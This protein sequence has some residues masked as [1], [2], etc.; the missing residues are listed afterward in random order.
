[1]TSPSPDP[2]TAYLAGV[3]RRDE[4]WHIPFSPARCC[5]LSQ[6]DVPRL[7]AAVEAARALHQPFSIYDE[8]EHD[9]TEAD[10]ASLAA[11]DAGEFLT[12]ADSLIYVICAGCCLGRSAGYGQTQDCAD[13]HDHGE[14]RPICPTHAAISAALLGEGEVGG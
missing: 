5:E 8:C 13:E 4:G 9:H 7:L 10:V 2:V 14:G 12:C 6:A 3:R 1:M 11:V